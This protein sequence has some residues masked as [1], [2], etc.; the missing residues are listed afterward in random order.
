MVQTT[1]LQLAQMNTNPDPAWVEQSLEERVDFQALATSEGAEF[2]ML[3]LRFLLQAGF[4]VRRLAF[5]VGGFPVDAEL[6]AASGSIY[7]LA[8]GTP[9]EKRRS[10]F[11]R[12]DTI[13]K[14]GFVAMN[15]AKQPGATRVLL[16]TSD[17]PAA[18]TK[19]AHYLAS[20]GGSVLDCVALRDDLE[21]FQRLRQYAL[22]DPLPELAARWRGGSC[23]PV[24]VDGQL[25]L[26]FI[27]QIR[28]REDDL[29]GASAD[30][31]VR[32][33]NVVEF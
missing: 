2:K 31:P 27:N 10:G 6:I 4:G 9:D 16:I 18:A 3:A 32:H 23:E 30:V 21:G 17:L 8:R 20:L 25:T 15:L 29:L 14:A 5:E 12:T 19:A 11:R 1:P 28:D 33:L 13:Q 22:I 26:P 24:T 7:L